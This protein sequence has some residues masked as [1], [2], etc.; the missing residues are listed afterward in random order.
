MA[1]PTPRRAERDP[2]T[3]RAR[4]A[5]RTTPKAAAG[6]TTPKIATQSTTH[7]AETYSADL[8]LDFARL[9]VAIVGLGATVALPGALF[10]WVAY[11]VMAGVG[12]RVLALLP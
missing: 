12:S 9:L 4:T 7:E 11:D 10:A 2:A 5:G 1:S 3:A 8:H 6:W